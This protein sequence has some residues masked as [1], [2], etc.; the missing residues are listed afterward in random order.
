MSPSPWDAA[1]TAASVDGAGSETSFA[2]TS[3][4]QHKQEKAWNHS[5]VGLRGPLEGFTSTFLSLQGT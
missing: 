3:T 5:L 1:P 2:A 4:C